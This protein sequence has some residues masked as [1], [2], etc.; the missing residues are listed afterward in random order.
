[1]NFKEA[2]E[3]ALKEHDHIGTPIL[4]EEY[5]PVI[6]GL[7]SND[8]LPYYEVE[9]EIVDTS[10]WGIVHQAVYRENYRYWMVTYEE[11]ATEM[12]D[13][14][15]YGTTIYEVESYAVTVTKYRKI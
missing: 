9:D 3:V 15:S 11:P 2:L 1:M 14:D 5:V 7:G 4:I 6:M 10:R 12:Q 8:E 13:W